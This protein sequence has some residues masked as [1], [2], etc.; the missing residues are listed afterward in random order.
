MAVCDY[1]GVAFYFQDEA[2]LAMGEMAILV[3]YPTPL[4]LHATGRLKGTRFQVVGRVRYRYS[5]GMWDEWYLRFDDGTYGWIVDDEME[6]SIEKEIE[7]P[8]SIP[9]YENVRPGSLLEVGGKSLSVDERDVAWLE[10]AEGSLPWVLSKDVE[11]PYL[12]ASNSELMVTV[13][14]SE[15]GAE[16]FTGERIELA[17]ISLDHPKEDFGGADWS[18]A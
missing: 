5:K 16:V 10:G 2:V 8:D 9:D 17:E 6:F 14:Y 18:D 7:T 1:C 4:Y 11:F 13:E 3:D 12:E 15:D